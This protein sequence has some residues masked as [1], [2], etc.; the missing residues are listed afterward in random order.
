MRPEKELFWRNKVV[1]RVRFWM[2]SG[3]SPVKKLKETS[4]TL[5]CGERKNGIPPENL[6][7]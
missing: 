1:R 3:T 4:M 2:V 7:S 5:S 6:F